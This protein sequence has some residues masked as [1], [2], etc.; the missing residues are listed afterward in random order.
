MK[1]LK[2]AVFSDNFY[3]EISG[4][5]D[6]II[7]TAKELAK[8]GHKIQFYVPKHPLRNYNKIN[9]T[10]KEVDLGKNISVV[11]LPSLPYK[12]GTGQSRMVIPLGWSLKSVKKF[13]PDVIHVHL[14]FGTGIEGL[15][16]SKLFKIPLVGTTHT[17]IEEYLRYARINSVKIKNIV[18]KAYSSFYN[19]CKIVSSPCK[20]GLDYFNDI[21]F[22]PKKIIIPNPYFL[23]NI[24]KNNSKTEYNFSGF[25]IV[26]CGRI[27][28]EKHIEDVIKS[29]PLIKNKIKSA[30][31]LIIGQGTYEN[32]LR[33]IVNRLGVQENVIFLGFLNQEQIYEIYKKCHVFAIMSTVEMQSLSVMQAMSSKLPIVGADSHGLSEQIHKDFGFLV[34][35]G[36]YKNL[37][38]KIIFL[39]ENENERIKMGENCAKFVKQFSAKK[40]ANTWEK[41]FY[42]LLNK[43]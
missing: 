8:K 41:I 42:S 21:K 15:I 33:N 24:E 36:D 19:Q 30:K 20:C 25:N 22:K 32:Y 6:S 28:E 23:K 1:K 16:A 38:K 14:P 29:M 17:A 11:R 27:A 12:T 26:Y 35:P 7:A 31:L 5:S 2:I 39:G 40:I 10:K 37:A 3:P 9:A 18:L 13:N 4:I 34:N 43:N